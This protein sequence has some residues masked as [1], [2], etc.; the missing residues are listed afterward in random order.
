MILVQEARLEML[1]QTEG[2]RRQFDDDE[3][4]CNVSFLRGISKSQ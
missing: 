4:E 2:A 1:W 3:K